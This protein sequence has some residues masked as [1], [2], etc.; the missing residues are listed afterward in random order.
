LIIFRLSIS[1]YCRQ[2]KVRLKW[3]NLSHNP[4]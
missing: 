3:D 1:S 2:K 4:L